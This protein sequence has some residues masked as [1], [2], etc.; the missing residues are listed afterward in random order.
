[1]F[2][3]LVSNGDGNGKVVWQKIGRVEP[4]KWFTVDIK[5]DFNGKT[6]DVA[7]DGGEWQTGKKF[8]HASSWEGTMWARGLNARD[9][10]YDIEAG[11]SPV[12]VRDIVFS[13]DPIG[14]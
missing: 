4:N 8:R 14:R 12:L 2:D 6:C 5:M 7:L 3:V 11:K 1:M 13:S 10:R 9:Y